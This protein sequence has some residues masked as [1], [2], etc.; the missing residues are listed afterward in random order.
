[1]NKKQQRKDL[2]VALVK[3]IED[4]LISVNPEATKKVSDI[5]YGAS[6]IL[7]KKF[8]KSVKNKEE[9]KA[10]P[11]KKAAQKKTAPKKATKEATK[12]AVK[13]TTKPS[14]SKA[15]SKK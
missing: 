14:V 11:A 8:Y 7:A 5:I 3:H 15:K 1:M 9:K 12:P 10:A 6:K 2:E 13:K 4:L